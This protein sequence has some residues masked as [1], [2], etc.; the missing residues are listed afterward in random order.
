MHIVMK[1]LVGTSALTALITGAILGYDYAFTIAT[2][3]VGAR[4]GLKYALGIS[5]GIG[6]I[7]VCG[8]ICYSLWQASKNK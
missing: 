8:D 4:T 3:S 1:I 2:L 6:V 5:S 7:L